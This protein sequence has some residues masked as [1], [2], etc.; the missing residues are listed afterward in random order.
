MGS[1]FS[2]GPFPKPVKRFT[3][4]SLVCDASHISVSRDAWWQAEV[5]RYIGR[6]DKLINKRYKDDTFITRKQFQQCF[7]ISDTATY[8]LFRVFD[9]AGDGRVASL[10]VWGAL[11]LAGS[12]RVEEKIKFLFELADRNGDHYLNPLDVE[13]LLR[14]V[15]R[16]FS[17][18]KGNPIPETRL[19]FQ[20][21]E[22]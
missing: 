5:I 20:Y 3:N 18:L 9:P 8:T 22:W 12:F 10:D 19:R 14:C 11:T 6:V 17:R 21:F 7:E 16:G 4:L 13:L 1:G 2:A 15:S